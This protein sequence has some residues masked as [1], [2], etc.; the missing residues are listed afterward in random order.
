M[1][2]LFRIINFVSWPASNI[3][4]RRLLPS[5]MA[6][7]AIFSTCVPAQGQV[8]LAPKSADPAL[9]GLPAALNSALQLHPSLASQQALVR[10]KEAN[11]ESARAAR[12]PTLGGS[13]GSGQ[14]YGHSGARTT[15]VSARQTL[16]AFGRIDS[17]ITY[18]DRDTQAQQA[19][20]WAIRRELLEQTAVAYA[21]V[22][23]VRERLAVAEQSVTRHLELQQQIQRRAE[24]GLASPV[25]VSMAQ[26]RLL[27]ARA[28]HATA[29]S[30]LRTA[31]SALLGLTQEL[32]RSDVPVPDDNLWLPNDETVREQV[33][34]QSAAIKARQATLELAESDVERERTASRPTVYLEAARNQ[35]SGL[36]NY[37]SSNTV[38]IVIS[39]NM[40]GLG[41]VSQNRSR[42]ALERVESARQ[43]LAQ[44]RH[45][46]DIQTRQLLDQRDANLALLQGYTQSVAE[47]DGTL[48]SF[49]RQYESGYKSWLDVL[50]AV[51]E[52]AEQQS[53][54]VQARAAW[55]ASSLRLAARIGHLDDPTGLPLGADSSRVEMPR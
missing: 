38:N 14:T 44:Q 27:Q 10:S 21:N 11:A 41:L 35:Y 40:E 15:T 55:R 3:T 36:P 17:A 37:T 48:A 32:V 9:A 4:Y 8:L 2:S 39:G 52:L 20:T 34:I 24:G 33:L 16:W 29:A 49:R 31:E 25:D 45:E 1:H 13:I 46:Q 43:D 54:Q 23:G 6:C 22:Q 7:G 28:A 42:A 50:N 53:A 5:L 12:Y 26:A 19:S 51:R 47:L 18:A 30:D